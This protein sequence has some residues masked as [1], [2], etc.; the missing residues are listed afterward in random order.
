MC[1]RSPEAATDQ[2]ICAARIDGS[3]SGF[4]YGVQRC[5]ENAIKHNNFTQ[6]EPLNVA[7]SQ[8][9]EWLVVSN[10]LQKKK[11]KAAS[12]NY[13][14]ANLA[15]RYRLW[16]GDEIIIK[17]DGDTFSVSIKLLKNENSNY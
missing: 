1:S 17:E 6:E 4:D 13:G 9:G 11:T 3:R 2:V 8:D 7:I 16:S 5:S 10:N 12:A 14:L 15:E